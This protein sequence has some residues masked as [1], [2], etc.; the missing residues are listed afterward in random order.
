MT[1]VQRIIVAS[2]EWLTVSASLKADG[3][4]PGWDCLQSLKDGLWPL[5]AIELP[6]EAQPKFF[7]YMMSDFQDLAD[8]IDLE[9]KGHNR[10]QDGIWE[11]KRDAV[12]LT[13]FDTPGDGSYLPKPGTKTE[14]FD[15]KV[16]YQLDTESLDEHVRVGYAFSKVSQKTRQ[17]D[18]DAAATVRK[19]D[20]YHDTI[21][22]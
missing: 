19:E 22:R 14:E 11:L 4:S 5:P 17:S 16:R 10:L 13:F 18:L 20:L 6:D 9:P 15:G 1:K 7:Y 12:R 3:T 2:G 8:G 21:D